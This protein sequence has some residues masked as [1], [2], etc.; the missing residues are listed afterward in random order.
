MIKEMN[1]AMSLTASIHVS[2]SHIKDVSQHTP[3]RSSLILRQK[4]AAGDSFRCDDTTEVDFYVNNQED[5]ED[6]LAAY[7]D[8]K[9]IYRRK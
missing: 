1:L 2:S 6:V 3:K 5:E 9:E 7:R 8:A 4:R